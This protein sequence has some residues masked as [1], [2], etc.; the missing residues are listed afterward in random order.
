M[1]VDF[2]APL[3]PMSPI[4]SLLVYLDIGVGEHLVGPE[5]LGDRFGSEQ[6]DRPAQCTH[7]IKK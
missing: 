7:G 3:M 6:H 5:R 1:K 4:A 2:P